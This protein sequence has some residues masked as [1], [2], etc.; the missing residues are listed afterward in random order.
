MATAVQDQPPTVTDDQSS[1]IIAIGV[2]STLIKVF[3][4]AFPLGPKQRMVI[5]YLWDNRYRVHIWETRPAPETL[6]KTKEVKVDCAFVVTQMENE[7]WVL[8]RSPN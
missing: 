2:N 8:E 6:L 4:E 1:K 5:N 7:H 3:Q